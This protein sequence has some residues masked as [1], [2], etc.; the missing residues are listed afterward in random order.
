MRSM[1]IPNHVSQNGVT[2]LA[3]TADPWVD[4]DDDTSK[5]THRI[6]VSQPTPAQVKLLIPV[7]LKLSNMS[8]G[9]SPAG[10]VAK[11][12]ILADLVVAHGSIT[13]KLSTATIDLEGYAPPSVSD[14][15]GSYGSEGSNCTTDNTFSAGLLENAIKTD[16]KSRAQAIASG[17]GDIHVVVFTAEQ[18]DV[19]CRSCPRRNHW[20]RR[21][22][23]V[24]AGHLL[25]MAA[26]L[27]R[28]SSRL[29]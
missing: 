1:C 16:L 23:V 14:A 15:A 4:I 13:A 18:I 25:P 11:L 2:F 10:V 12:S 21:Y 3:F 5:P 6:V 29:P 17:I 28:T 22:R 9:L 20:S 19:H 26:S 27:S 8:S 24:N 7:H